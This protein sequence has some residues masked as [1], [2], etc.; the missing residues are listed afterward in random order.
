VAHSLIV[1]QRLQRTV[2]EN[3]A[4]QNLG[5]CY[6]ESD[7]KMETAIAAEADRMKDEDEEDEGEEETFERLLSESMMRLCVDQCR[8][9]KIKVGNETLIVA[10]SHTDDMLNVLPFRKVPVA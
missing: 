10:H 6:D 2:R 8:A 7:P 5:G 1:R 3:I 9:P 4:I